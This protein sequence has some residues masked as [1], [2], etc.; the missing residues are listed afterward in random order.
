ML[1][2]V[3]ESYRTGRS[4]VWNRVN[5]L[6]DF[7]YFNHAIH[8]NKG[9]GCSTCHGPVHEMPLTWRSVSLNMEW[10]LGCHRA[11]EKY[12]RPKTAIFDTSWEPPADQLSVGLKLLDEYRIN[13]ADNRLTNCSICHR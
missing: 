3:R 6:A 11:P 2:P 7:A 1:E 13:T 9:V 5:R 10:C 12:L 4:I 8:V